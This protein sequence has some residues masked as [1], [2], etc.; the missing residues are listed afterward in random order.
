MQVSCNE[1]NL[2][3]ITQ[4]NDQ[5][6]KF[7][8]VVEK[9]ALYQKVGNF[10]P[11][12][13]AINH[14]AFLKRFIKSE[15]TG[16]SYKERMIYP[17]H[18]SGFLVPCTTLQRLLPDLSMG[19]QF[20]LFLQKIKFEEDEGIPNLSPPCFILIDDTGLVIGA[21]FDSKKLLNISVF[22]IN[23]LFFFSQK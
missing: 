20:V 18:R 22:Q 10:M 23:F 21:S 16:S 17:L 5:I 12:I 3:T 4:V 19:I 6:Y 15:V 11:K 7:L 2:G 13:F 14:D 1:G 8:G 9:D